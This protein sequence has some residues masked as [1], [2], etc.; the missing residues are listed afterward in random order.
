MRT[1]QALDLLSY[2]NLHSAP[3]FIHRRANST[4]D[5]YRCQS[6]M[7]IADID[8]LGVTSSN[9]INIVGF[10][11]YLQ[12]PFLPQNEPL[13]TIRICQRRHTEVSIPLFEGGRRKCIEHR[14]IVIGYAGDLSVEVLGFVVEDGFHGG[15]M[16]STEDLSAY[17]IGESALG[18]CAWLC[19]R[20]MIVKNLI[21]KKRPGGHH[22]EVV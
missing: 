1:F 12:G 21:T 19:H 14:V 18:G 13:C 5:V 6:V 10:P 17:R 7:G 16:L 4:L 9:F 22:E 3:A 11:I 20:S 15:K 2:T 8:S